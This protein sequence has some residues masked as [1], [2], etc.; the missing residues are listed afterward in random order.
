MNAPIIRLTA[1]A[2]GGGCG[3]KLSPAVLRELLAEQPAAAPFAKLLVGTETGDDAAVWRLERRHLRWSRP[4][5]SSCRWSTT[6]ST[7]AASPRPTRSPTS[8]RWA[9]SRSWRWRSS[10]CRSASCRPSRSREILRRRRGDLRRGGHPGRGRP[11]DRFAPSRSTASRSM[12]SCIRPGRATQLGRAR[13][14]RADPDQAARRRRS[15]RAAIKK[16]ALSAD[17]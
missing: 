7:S 12:G 2:H 1:L 16:G 6:R 13:R 10:A 15:I 9:A 17:G 4:P 8:M 14:R 11:L 3:C 5:T